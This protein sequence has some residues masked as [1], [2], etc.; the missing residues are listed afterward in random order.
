MRLMDGLSFI[1][2]GCFSCLKWD[3]TLHIVFYFYFFLSLQCSIVLVLKWWIIFS[4]GFLFECH[5]VLE[6]SSFIGLH[7]R[8]MVLSSLFFLWQFCFIILHNDLFILFYFG[9]VTCIYQ[10]LGCIIGL[11]GKN[12]IEKYCRWEKGKNTSKKQPILRGR[13][14]PREAA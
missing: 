11:Y 13:W 9:M 4:Y 3:W 2:N 14:Q 1:W 6:I 5:G 10:K 7:E 12:Q 8:N